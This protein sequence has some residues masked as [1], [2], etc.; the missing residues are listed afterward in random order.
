MKL[1]GQ[2]FDSGIKEAVGFKVRSSADFRFVSQLNGCGF[3]VARLISV[4]LCHPDKRISNL[5]DSFGRLQSDANYA[6]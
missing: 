6:G 1:H 3:S 4:D 2:V 5:G